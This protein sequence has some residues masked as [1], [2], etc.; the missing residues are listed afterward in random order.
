MTSPPVPPPPRCSPSTS[1]AP[2]NIEAL[3]GHQPCSAL[4][5]QG[6]PTAS[7]SSP[8]SPL[9]PA[10]V[11][12]PT[13]PLAPPPS[14]LCGASSHAGLVPISCELSTRCCLMALIQAEPLP[15]V[16][17]LPFSFTDWSPK[18][19]TPSTREAK[20]SSSTNTCQVKAGYMCGRGRGRVAAAPWPRPWPSPCPPPAEE[21]L[22]MTGAGRTEAW[23]WPTTTPMASHAELVAQASVPPHVAP[24]A[25]PRW[26]WVPRLSHRLPLWP[27]GSVPSGPPASSGTGAGAVPTTAATASSSVGGPGL[28]PLQGGGCL[29][30][31]VSM[32]RRGTGG[33]VGE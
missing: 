25:L 7:K 19:S 21:D 8:L 16:F 29:D 23:M 27:P 17:F 15:A 9:S 28:A 2:S 24:S 31:A 5:L 6:I 11:S 3:E 1:H 18:A 30:T 14:P 33:G 13:T 26:S 10:L 20:S 4:P 32:P 12:L 22:P